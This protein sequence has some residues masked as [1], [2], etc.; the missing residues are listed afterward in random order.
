[1]KTA[2]GKAVRAFLLLSALA[3][4]HPSE[5]PQP[6]HALA[7]SDA[8][9]ITDTLSLEENSEVVNVNIDV[10]TDNDSGFVVAD[11]A[12]GQV[13]MYD[14]TGRLSWFGG[15]RGAG[16]GEFS[17]LVLA[18]RMPDGS[19]LC[20]DRNARFTVFDTTEGRCCTARSWGQI[21]RPPSRD[22]VTR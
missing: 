1:M 16:P 4:E 2:F 3:C 10:A 20:A 22:Q 21:P 8:I 18:R 11:R 15:G 17:N 14:R 6:A 13:R 9:Q 5:D 7:F 19:L 12:E